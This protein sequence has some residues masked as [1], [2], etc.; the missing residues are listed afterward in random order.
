[1]DTKYTKCASKVRNN[2]LQMRKNSPKR[3]IGLSYDVEYA[4]MAPEILESVFGTNAKF[5]YL[6]GIVTRQ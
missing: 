6:V 4:K 5:Y 1:M 3:H 2:G